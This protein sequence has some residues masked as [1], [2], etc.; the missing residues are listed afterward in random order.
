MQTRFGKNPSLNHV[1]CITAC[2]S[3]YCEF[4]RED[5]LHVA[6]V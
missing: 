2:L 4:E 3:H 5:Q 1:T 6:A